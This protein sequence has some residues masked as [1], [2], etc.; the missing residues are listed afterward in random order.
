MEFTKERPKTPGHYEY[1][2]SLNEDSISIFVEALYSEHYRLIA[3]MPT[4]VTFYIDEDNCPESMYYGPM[5][6]CE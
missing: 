5:R 4:N 2:N 6:R 3:T 1:K